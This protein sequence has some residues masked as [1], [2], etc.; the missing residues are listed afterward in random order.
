MVSRAV[1]HVISVECSCC[2]SY[3]QPRVED[4]SLQS[5]RGDGKRGDLCFIGVERVFC[6]GRREFDT[7]W[8]GSVAVSSGRGAPVVPFYLFLG[9]LRDGVGGTGCV[10]RNEELCVSSS[11]CV[12]LG[13]D[14]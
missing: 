12:V 5:L 3:L 14:R 2:S 6:H 10:V 1:Q 7:G 4:C 11:G 8:D 13:P 9:F